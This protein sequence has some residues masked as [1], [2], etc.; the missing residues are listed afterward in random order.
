MSVL[1]GCGA[2]GG[3]WLS[4]SQSSGLS[5]QLNHVTAALGS[6][7]C[8]QAKRYLSQFDSRVNRLGGVDSTL[9]ANLNQGASTIKSLVDRS[10]VV[11][12]P[13]AKKPHPRTTTATNT[14]PSTPTFT[15]PSTPT[16]TQPT[17]TQP[18]TSTPSTTSTTGG[19]CPT[20]GVTTTTTTSTP[21]TTTPSGGT[22][23]GAGGAGLPSD[24][25]TNPVPGGSSTPG[26][27]AGA[28]GNGG[29]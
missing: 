21:S 24:A 12:P 27:A 25:T 5:A 15:T 3:S 22:G 20:C 14:T 9:V 7:Q 11:V 1:A 6:G 26:G 28:S 8:T 4:A 23:L 18:T 13:A 29:L 17:P 2:S 10:C 16:Y 19:V